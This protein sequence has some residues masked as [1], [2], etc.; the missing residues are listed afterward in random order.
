MDRKYACCCGLYCENCAVKVKVEPAAKALYEEMN[1]L[2]FA[3][4]MQFFPDG[5]KFWAFLKGMSSEGICISCKAGSGNPACKIRLCA[6]E[7]NIEICALCGSYPCEH[8]TAFFE[9]YPMLRNDNAVLREK[10]WEAWAKLQD[11][12]RTEGFTFFY[13]KNSGEPDND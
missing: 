1:L 9:G 2:G 11:E 4:I 13:S 12:R 8:F 6:K 5:E 3:E 7:K 10:G